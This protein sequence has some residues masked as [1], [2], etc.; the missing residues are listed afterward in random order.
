[1]PQLQQCAWEFVL[2]APVFAALL[3]AATASALPPAENSAEEVQRL[4]LMLRERPG[5]SPAIDSQVR[6]EAADQLAQIGAAG[7]AAVPA[8]RSALG[9]KDLVLRVSLASAL[10]SIELEPSS[11]LAP[12]LVEGLGGASTRGKALRAL[13]GMGPAAAA[14]VPSLIGLLKDGDPDV[15]NRAASV[16][17][18]IGPG[19]V[20]AAPALAQE[21]DDSRAGELWR[22]AESALVDIGPTAVPALVNGVRDERTRV[23]AAHALNSLRPEAKAAVPALMEALKDSRPR[24]RSMACYGLAGIGPEARAAARSLIV[25]LA[26]T[27]RDVRFQAAYALGRIGP[28]AADAIPALTR[29]LADS[30]NDVARA[31]A[32][33]L[34]SMGPAA[35]TPLV[36]A[37]GSA[38]PIVRAEAAVSL[39]RLG[40]QG[41]PES[42]VLQAA[43]KDDDKLVRC[44]AAQALVAVEPAAGTKTLSMLQ[45]ELGDGICF[46]QVTGALGALGR[47][48]L[49]VLING[50]RDSREQTRNQAW[51]TLSK[52]DPAV[53]REATPDLVA[54][55]GDP[56]EEVRAIVTQLLAGLKLD[57]PGVYTALKTTLGDRTAKV[58]TAAAAALIT[59]GPEG[60][61]LAL[62]VLKAALRDPDKLSRFLTA[63]ALA[64]GDHESKTAAMPA[65]LE[66]LNEPEEFEAALKFGRLEVIRALGEMG[67]DARSAIPGLIRSFKMG[68]PHLQEGPPALLG[69]FKVC[70]A[71][72]TALAR[73]DGTLAPF[74]VSLL[75]SALTTSDAGLRFEAARGLGQIGP[76]AMA[77]MPALRK[78]CKDEVREVRAAATAASDR[79][80]GR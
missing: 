41:K 46:W 27:A 6:R 61:T 3:L 33:A 48:A 20:A 7:V 44:S 32:T 31:A 65:L 26:D 35:V 11:D 72:A 78:A 14:A 34:S 68:L 36:V 29:A 58:R 21:L 49:P 63:T 55:L 39:G 74:G 45:Q 53:L 15:R 8:L 56:R 5:E 60:R 23:I 57:D 69:D 25:A 59:D 50:L 62:P 37:L 19:A 10:V 54:A 28:D 43:L 2:L 77:A 71:C 42:G 18:N 80:Q 76:P 38:N 73:I 70:L 47:E 12:L 66:A 51:F 64:K 79:I 30:S 13:E 75:V 17:G 1:M 40:P 24:A 22:F 16:L 67:P 9:A 52:L 4:I